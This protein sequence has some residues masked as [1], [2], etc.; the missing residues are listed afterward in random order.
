MIIY[1]PKLKSKFPRWIIILFQCFVFI[2]L[3]GVIP[4]L[5]L[6]L[7]LFQY[8]LFENGFTYF[9]VEFFIIFF[10]YKNMITFSPVDR[11]II[12]DSKSEIIIIYWLMYF[13]KRKLVVK[14]DEL[15]FRAQMSGAL[16]GNSL[17]ISIF[18]NK[19][20]KIKLNARN[21][22]TEEQVQKIY[23]YLLLI[24]KGKIRTRPWYS[25]EE[26]FPKDE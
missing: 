2:V 15:S 11:F 22:W 1:E 18:K 24:T 7:I 19:N 9:V 4:C 17:S 26:N 13:I 23:E 12:D 25:L 6:D 21:G 20:Y 8:S 5:Q 16:W 3:V 10:L 14:Y